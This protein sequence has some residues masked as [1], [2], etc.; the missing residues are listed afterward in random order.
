MYYL[1]HEIIQM[2]ATSRESAHYFC[3]KKYILFLKI[4][5]LSVWEKY[6]RKEMK[7]GETRLLKP[8]SKRWSSQHI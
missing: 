2:L 8:P 1:I 7:L 3:L 6:R 4:R 5:N